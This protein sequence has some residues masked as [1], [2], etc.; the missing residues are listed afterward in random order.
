MSKSDDIPAFITHV[1]PVE[2][3][4]CGKKMTLQEYLAV[5]KSIPERMLS[6]EKEARILNLPYGGDLYH[7]EHVVDLN[8]VSIR[9]GERTI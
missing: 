9:Y 7:T 1:I 2:D 8:K 3:R 5:R 6:E 4:V